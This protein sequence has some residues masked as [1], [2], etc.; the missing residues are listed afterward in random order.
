[1]K[2]TI[3]ET[4]VIREPSFSAFFFTPSA[5][6]LA[7]RTSAQSQKKMGKLCDIWLACSELTLTISASVDPSAREEE[8]PINEISS[9]LI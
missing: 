5:I 9:A 2:R 1:M 3:I 8:I 6:A 4:Q 7:P